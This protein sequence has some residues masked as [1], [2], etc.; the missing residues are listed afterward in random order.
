MILYPYFPE[1]AA[2]A[3]DAQPSPAQNTPAG[4]NFGIDNATMPPKDGMALVQQI[5]EAV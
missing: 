2:N 5:L 3:A 1:P 4:G